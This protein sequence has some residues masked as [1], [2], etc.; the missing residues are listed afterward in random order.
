MMPSRF[1]V[2]LAVLV[3]ALGGILGGAAG[4]SRK[5]ITTAEQ[6]R[7]ERREARK[8]ERSKEEEARQELELIPPPSKN[9]YLSVRSQRAYQNPFLVVHARTITLTITF[10]DQK[11]AGIASGGMLRPVEAR[12]QQLELNLSGLSTA[13]AALP[14][15]VWPYGRV[16]AVEEPPN[17]PPQDRVV[18]RRN[19]ES[20]IQ[21]LNDLGVVV[22]EWTGPNG[23]LLR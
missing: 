5:A 11:P 7:A 4:C 1:P 9:L 23:A 2:L 16:V 12:V 17:A 10:P 20:A 18:I 3:L 21:T 22:D 8:A 6:A 13:L 19:I 14:A 15:E